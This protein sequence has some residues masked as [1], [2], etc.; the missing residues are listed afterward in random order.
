MNEEISNRTV[1]ILL[2]GLS[3]EQKTAISNYVT[4]SEQIQ[5]LSNQ[6]EEYRKQV[7]GNEACQLI[8]DIKNQ[9]AS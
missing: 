3:E 1:A 7:E 8:I 2:S 4:L 5:S 6:R 9:P